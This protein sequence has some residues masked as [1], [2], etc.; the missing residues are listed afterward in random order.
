MKIAIE[1]ITSH[2]S[3]ASSVDRVFETSKAQS[4]GPSRPN[5]KQNKNKE[6]FIF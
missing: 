6:D 3:I 2:Q 1:S 5:N 4:F